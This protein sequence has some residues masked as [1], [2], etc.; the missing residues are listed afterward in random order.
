MQGAQTPEPAWAMAQ[1]EQT[2]PYIPEMS[3]H[4]Q[5][6]VSVTVQNY[7]MKGWQ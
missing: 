6:D 3:D 5:Q 4:L 2:V 1:T 7:I